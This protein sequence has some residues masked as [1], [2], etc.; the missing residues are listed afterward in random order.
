MAR[1]LLS[2]DNRVFLFEGKFYVKNQESFDFFCRYLRVFDK[3]RLLVR[4][5]ISSSRNNQW[6]PLDIE[7]RLECVS[8]PDFKGEKKFFLKYFE[9]RRIVK[10]S[11]TN[12]DAAILRVPSI[13]ALMT[14]KF[15]KRNKI[16]YALEIVYDAEDGWKSESGISRFIWKRIDKELR[17]LCY[18]AYGVSCVTKRHMQKKYY[19]KKIGSFVSSYSSLSLPKDFFAH[20]PKKYV[21]KASY[22]IILVANQVQFNGR[23]GHNQVIQVAKLLKDENFCLN[24]RF[25]GADYD[26]GMQKLKLF[27]EK[28]GVGSQIE[29]L[30]YV[31]KDQIG[32]LL[33]SSDLFVLPTKAEGLPR[34]LIEAM[35]KALPCITTNVSGNSEL[36][37]HECLVEDFYDIESFASLV[38]HFITD[39][40]FY[41][42]MSLLNLQNSREF[43]E[44]LLQERRDEFYYNLRRCV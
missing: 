18:D 36:I 43:E 25:V 7:P 38:K 17:C 3:V 8:V 39:E 31:G 16:P 10:K 40:V 26:N 37:S 41:E 33:E 21:H 11:L 44:S 2:C 20:E 23:K 32:M 34:V 35:A 42:K 15:V 30:G 14:G 5:V 6:I 13:I 9:I 19:S 4:C 22:T 1:L 28:M 27:A 12:C 29:F 24:I